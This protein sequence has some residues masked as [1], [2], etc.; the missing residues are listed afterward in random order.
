MVLVCAA[1]EGS[2]K[3][4]GEAGWERCGRWG[5]WGRRRGNRGQ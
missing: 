2:E 5:C 3:R 4:R 1:G